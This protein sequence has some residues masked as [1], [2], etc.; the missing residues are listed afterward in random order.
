M[1]AT[2]A[3]MVGAHGEPTASFESASIEATR[4]WRVGAAAAP[5]SVS[6]AG[7]PL[8][9]PEHSAPI[10]TGCSC[11]NG[12]AGAIFAV[13]TPE[14][15]QLQGE[16]AAVPCPANSTGEDVASGCA[17]DEGFAGTIQATDNLERF[18]GMCSMRVACP[19]KSYGQDV[20]SGC[21]CELGY[22]GHIRQGPA[23]TWYLGICVWWGWIGVGA[24]A[25]C[26]CYIWFDV[27]QWACIPAHFA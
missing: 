19:D 22:F 9:C 7:A 21:T 16:C 11:D 20:P 10:E 14:G 17:C 8:L 3:A 5:P 18:T 12:Y 24:V 2:A 6:L 25:L 1:A 23:P 13:V 15:S 4:R 27:V 26:C